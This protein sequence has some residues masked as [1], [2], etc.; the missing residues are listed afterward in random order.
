MNAIFTLFFF[1]P[2]AFPSA[3]TAAKLGEE[4]SERNDRQKLA[5]CRCYLAAAYKSCRCCCFL[6]IYMQ[7]LQ[8]AVSTSSLK[9]SLALCLTLFSLS[10]SLLFHSNRHYG[11]PCC[12]VVCMCVCVKCLCVCASLTGC[13]G[14]RI[15]NDL[16][17]KLR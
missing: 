7:V 1:F 13:T 6:H 14:T 8:A 17:L 11:R 12:S 15:S 9:F 16:R 10:L 3:G 4:L 5:S 2:S